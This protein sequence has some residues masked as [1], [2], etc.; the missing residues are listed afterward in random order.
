[1]LTY[2]LNKLNNLAVIST[3]HIGIDQTDTTLQTLEQQAALEG[4][5]L[6][7]ASGD[8]QYGISLN[9]NSLYTASY[10]SSV[11]NNTSGFLSVGGINPIFTYN[12]G[13]IN[14]FSSKSTAWNSSQGGPSGFNNKP[15]WQ[16]NSVDVSNV[17][18]SLSDSQQGERVT[19]DIA[20]PASS[21]NIF[22][23]GSY[24]SNVTG[25]SFAAPLTAGVIASMDQFL[26]ERSDGPEG[27]MNPEIYAIGQ[28][29]YSAGT[30]LPFVD[31][32]VGSNPTTKFDA[33]RGYDLVTGWGVLAPYNYL[34]AQ[35]SNL[36]DI[37]N[38]N[39]VPNQTETSSFTFI[40]Q[41]KTSV[42]LQKIQLYMDSNLLKTC[43]YTP[44]TTDN[45]NNACTYSFSVTDTSNN[46][47]HNYYIH[48]YDDFGRENTMSIPF[49]IDYYTPTRGGGCVAQN[50]LI[51][52]AD[53]TTRKVQSLKVGDI[54]EGYDYQTHNLTS[55]ELYNITETS[56]NQLLVI[57]NGLLKLTPTDQ[58]IYMRNATYTGWLI[59]PQDL[60]VGDQIFSPTTGSWI[61]ITSLTYEIGNFKVYDVRTTPFNNFIANGILLDIKVQ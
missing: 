14:G 24:F 2:A 22:F 18:R 53:G 26:K 30:P 29:Q 61:T 49:T 31:I 57:N 56:V 42:G 48:A 28:T 25:T 39:P 32:T 60:K 1:M 20:G 50:T 13:I 8:S 5:T 21:I 44:Y 51:L 55:V 58:P 43:Q 35:Y 34:E 16:T 7:A 52:M 12:N 41:A 38:Y 10:P 17:I 45:Y 59:N 3:S 54:L 15:N 33:L 47:Q 19:P 9:K 40:A 46:G 6:V 23:N 11:C 37:Y 4:I 36:P 27:F